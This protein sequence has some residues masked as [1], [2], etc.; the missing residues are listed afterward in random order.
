MTA[1]VTVSIITREDLQDALVRCCDQHPASGNGHCLHP[2]AALM[3]DL[4]GLMLHFRKDS[5]ATVDINPAIIAAFE[6]WNKA[7]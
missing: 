1:T 4:F 3:A 5:T 7:E 2:D 6:R